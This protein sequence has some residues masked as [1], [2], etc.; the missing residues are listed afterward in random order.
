[1]PPGRRALN[2]TRRR[3]CTQPGRLSPTSA[4]SP[5]S[6]GSTRHGRR[7]SAMS[8][9]GAEPWSTESKWLGTSRPTV[10]NSPRPDS[11]SQDSPPTAPRGSSS[12]TTRAADWSTPSAQP[13]AA[14]SRSYGSTI[15]RF[16]PGTPASRIG[17]W[18]TS[19]TTSTARTASSSS[20]CPPAT[21]YYGFP[22]QPR[23]T[24]GMIL[25][26]PNGDVYK[27]GNEPGQPTGFLVRFS[28]P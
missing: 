8:G 14:G 13:T 18:C 26:M 15:L 25:F 10:P 20:T 16:A 2:A 17:G 12:P 4:T 7:Q 19:P 23:A 11:P 22:H 24:I 3:D 27:A 21:N 5:T 28:V 6:L 9:A 1:M